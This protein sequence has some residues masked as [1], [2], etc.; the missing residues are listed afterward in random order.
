MPDPPKTS[1]GT[2]ITSLPSLI[3]WLNDGCWTYLYNRPRH[4]SVIESMTMRSVRQAVERGEMRRCMKF[5]EDEPYR[6]GG[7]SA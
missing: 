5:G 6:S 3:K 7:D 1:P 2:H 4:P